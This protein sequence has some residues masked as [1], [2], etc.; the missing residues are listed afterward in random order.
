MNGPHAQDRVERPPKEYRHGFKK[1]GVSERYFDDLELLSRFCREN[2]VSYG[3]NPPPDPYFKACFVPGQGV[4][5]LPTQKAN[6][7][8]WERK[9]LR[10]HEWGHVWGWRHQ[11]PPLDMKKLM[12]EQQA[13]RLAEAVRGYAP[14]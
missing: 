5:A 9:D 3:A 10:E 13:G 7:D 2:G 1:E 4:V 8:P 12:A 6:P 11:A 14:R